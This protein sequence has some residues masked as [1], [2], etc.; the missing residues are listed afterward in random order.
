M[1]ATV[2]AAATF[3]VQLP[4]VLRGGFFLD[5]FRN[6]GQA[7]L[8]LD[9]FTPIGGEHFQPLS[10]A[11]YW[12]AAVPLQ[13]HYSR[14]EAMVAASVALGAFL[15][16]LLLDE[17][18][19]IR[20]L[21]LALAFVCGTSWLVLNTDQWLAAAPAS[22]A[23]VCMVG[24]SW[25]F[26]KWLKRGSRISYVASL[27]AAMFA[28]L[29]WEQAVALPVVLAL[30]WL[31]MARDARRT[32]DV[33]WALVPHVLLALALVAYVQSLHLTQ[34]LT[35]P[36]LSDW[37]LL[38]VVSTFHA[39]LP[40]IIGTGLNDGDPGAW[41]W[42]SIA[43]VSSAFASALVWLAVHR[44]LRLSALAFFLAMSAVYTAPAALARGDSGIVVVGNTPRYLTLLPFILAIA[45]AGVA[46]RGRPARAPA[47]WRSTFWV[48]PAALTVVNLGFTFNAVP[49]FTDNG[50]AAGIISHRVGSGVA[51]LGPASSSLVDTVLTYPMW[52][53]GHD[54]S[55]E[56]SKLLPF[57]FP[58]DRV[59]G[60]GSRIAVVGPDG[61]VRWATFDIGANGPQYVR[62]SALATKRTMLLVRIIGVRPTQPEAAFALTLE[63]GLQAFT[64][65]AW[66]TEVRSVSLQ[67]GAGATA[68][69]DVGVV[70]AGQIVSG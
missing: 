39:V 26:V 43:I 20:R 44:R 16:A 53:P 24:A 46:V 35:V 13:E 64:L 10:R 2:V 65:P 14:V 33:I 34:P 61:F 63:P 18:F 48:L 67:H 59:L 9:L 30:I 37:F 17:L 42:A 50:H 3:A 1:P 15:L 49:L 54:G 62:I 40:S 68:S 29:S 52:Y 25:G 31:C 32:R 11:L 28:L 47:G 57:W 70:E 22:V 5:D 45:V 21:H 41:G 23:A 60:A 6:L 55:G 27:F 12:I 69:V 36:R 19:G 66:S 4:F 56:V 38:L 58:A 7:R 51:A 8:G